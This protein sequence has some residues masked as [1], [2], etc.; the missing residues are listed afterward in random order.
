MQNK[1][2]CIPAYSVNKA[3]NKV[4][5]LRLPRKFVLDVRNITRIIVLIVFDSIAIASGWYFVSTNYIHN[6]FFAYEPIDYEINLLFPSVLFIGISFLSVCQAYRRGLKSRNIINSS[7]AITFSYLA[8]LPIAWQLYG[9]SSLSYIF[10]AWVITLLLINSFRFAL[11][12]GLL[13]LREKY[14]PWKIKVMLIGEQND[15]AQCLPLLENSKEFQVAGQLD[16]SNF[17]DWERFISTFERLDLKKQNIGEIIVC[18]WEKIK[19]S[20]KFLWKL[21]CSGIYWRILKF[22]EKINPNNL[23]ISQL[24]GVTTMRICDSAIVGIDFLN[25]RIFDIIASSILLIILGLPM[26]AIAILIKL[27]SSGSV[28]YKQTRVGL[29]GRYFKVWKFRTMVENASQ[30]QAQLEAR[31]EVSG[32]VLFKIKDDPRITRVGKILRKYSLDELPQLF[33]VLRGEMS[34]VG[35]RPL[36]V[37]DVERFAPEHYFRHEVLPGIT[38][39]WQVSGRSDTD[40]ENVFNLDFEYIQNWSLALDFKILFKTVG[41][42]LNSKGAY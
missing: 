29:K 24:E 41:V 5:D 13:Y 22:N 42:V 9:N 39:L 21:R 14:F 11:F 36:P 18:S 33:N 35:P 40:S 15:I 4:Q 16:I 27:D 37:R 3:E 12:Q 8:L 17:E 26:L 20:Q 28:L 1:D 38:G 7:K 31:N 2:I 19:D 23:E 6:F 25:K 10:W 30:L 34:L 32:G